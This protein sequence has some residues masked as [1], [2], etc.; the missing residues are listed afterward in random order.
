MNGGKC[1]LVSKGKNN[2]KNF[3]EFSF[4]TNNNVS[5]TQKGKYGSF[6]TSL[7]HI[8][9]KGQ[10]PN[11]KLNKLTYTV[12]GDMKFKNLSVEGGLTYNKK[13]LSQRLWNWIRCRW[14][15]I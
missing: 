7:T 13:V 15:H 3:L 6:R 1:L 14:L 9:N 11:T 5:V 4:V 10:Y 8:Y 12:G 2:F